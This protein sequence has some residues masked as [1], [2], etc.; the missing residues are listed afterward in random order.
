[1]V[2]GM[3]RRHYYRIKK[4]KEGKDGKKYLSL[5]LKE[6]QQQQQQQ[7]I[8]KRRNEYRYCIDEKGNV[9]KKCFFLKA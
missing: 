1:M 3:N 5:L 2:F 6:N 7:K 9:K 8:E 4:I